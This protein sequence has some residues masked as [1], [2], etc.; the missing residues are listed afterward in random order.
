MTDITM[1]IPWHCGLKDGCTQGW[2]QATYWDTEDGYTVDA[3]SDGDH[4]DVDPEDLPSGEEEVA[5][6]KDYA[7][8][9]AETGTDPLCQY[10][11]DRTVK[12]TESWQFT[13]QEWIGSSTHGPALI[14]ARQNSRGPFLPGSELPE[15]VQEFLCLKKVGGRYVL[16]GFTGIPQLKTDAVEVTWQGCGQGAKGVCLIENT[17]PRPDA[18]VA[19]ELKAAA[20]PGSPS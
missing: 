15:H 18:V 13:A 4:E 10:R 12:R 11:V 2:H 7:A 14:G 3:Y 1:Q 6:W 17:V 16:E 9:V 8:Y 20:W 19:R 5:A